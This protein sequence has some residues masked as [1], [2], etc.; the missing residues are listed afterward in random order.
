MALPG[1]DLTR[2]V[3]VANEERSDDGRLESDCLLWGNRV[4]IPD[5]LQQHILKELHR[6]HQGIVRMTSLAIMHV[7]ILARC[8]SEY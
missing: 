7:Y 3:G 8:R 4:I 6:G 5:G 2:V 1:Q